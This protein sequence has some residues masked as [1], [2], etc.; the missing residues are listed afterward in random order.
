[1]HSELNYIYALVIFLY[2]AGAICQRNKLVILK[3]QLIWGLEAKAFSGPHVN[4]LDDLE[5]VFIT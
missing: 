1:M 3:E 5:Q 2:C 4:L